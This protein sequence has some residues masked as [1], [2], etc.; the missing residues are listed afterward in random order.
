MALTEKLR[1]A[2]EAQGFN[3]LF[4]EHEPIWTE[5]ANDARNLIRPHVQGGEPTV[6]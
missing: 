3:R 6:D 1:L 4:E 5:L 2:L